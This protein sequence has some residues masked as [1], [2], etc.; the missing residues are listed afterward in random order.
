MVKAPRRGF[1]PPQQTET[2][3]D[4]LASIIFP[5][6]SNTRRIPP[7]KSTATNKCCCSRRLVVPQSSTLHYIT[8]LFIFLTALS[9]SQPSTT[10]I[11][12]GGTTQN[13][14]QHLQSPLPQ[15]FINHFMTFFFKSI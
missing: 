2:Q 6:P 4:Q 11:S 10:S 15:V 1:C 5:Q 8:F 9:I 3:T 14:G 13:S 12:N 7:A